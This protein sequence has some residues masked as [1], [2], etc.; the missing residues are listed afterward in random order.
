M[1]WGHLQLSTELMDMPFVGIRIDKSLIS[2][3]L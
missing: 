3:R 2:M 1:Q